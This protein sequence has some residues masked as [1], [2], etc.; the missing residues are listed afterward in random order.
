MV[1]VKVSAP[2]LPA[3]IKIS[4]KLGEAGVQADKN[5]LDSRLRGNDI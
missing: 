5:L 1:F 2:V 4:V 3:G